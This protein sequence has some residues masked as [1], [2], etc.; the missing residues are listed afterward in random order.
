MKIHYL[1]PYCIEGIK[2]H[3]E[4]IKISFNHDT[5]EKDNMICDFCNEEDE[6]IIPVEY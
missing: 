6:N 2:S 4:K 5:K 1:C 3:G